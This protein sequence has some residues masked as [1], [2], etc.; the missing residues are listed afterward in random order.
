[1]SKWGYV[2]R[3]GLERNCLIQLIAAVVGL[4]LALCLILAAVLLAASLPADGSGT[5]LLWLFIC[6]MPLGLLLLGGPAAAVVIVTR[7]RARRLDELFAPLGL[8]GSSYAMTGRQYHGRYR[9]RQLDVHIYRGPGLR[10]SVSADVTT[11]LS[12]AAAEDVVQSL[13]KRFNGPPLTHNQPDL[14]GIVIFTHED[15]WGQAFAADPTIAVLVRRL[16][17][18]ENS[19]LFRQVQ[20]QPGAVHLQLWRTD[21]MLRLEITAEQVAEWTELLL[22]LADQVERLPHRQ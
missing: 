6:M 17:Q 10:F 19:F 16:I 5:T 4:P 13:A 8:S 7:R 1:M 11:R 15:G 12:A 9:H 20:I 2:W 21:R 3:K 18:G 22:Q 14:E